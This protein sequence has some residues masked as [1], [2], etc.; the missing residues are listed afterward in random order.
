MFIISSIVFAAFLLFQRRYERVYGPRT[1]LGSLRNWQRTPKRS[2]G[3]LGWRKEYSLLKDEYILGHASIDNYLWLRFFKVLII[4]CF[5]GCLITWPVLFAVNAS[6]HAPG[7]GL[8]VLS[9]SHINPGPRYYASC[10][11]AWV[12]LGFVMF[13]ITRESRYYIRLRQQYYISPF[14]KSRISSRTVLFVQVPEELR[15]EEALRREFAGVKKVWLVNVPE[16]LAKDVEDRDKAA[17]KLENG[18]IKLLT[19]Y[20]KR[21][22]KLEK[23][24]QA[25]PSRDGGAPALD[26]KDRPSHRLPILK[27]IPLGKKVDTIDWSRSELH[28][29]IPQIAR[30]QHEHRNDNSLPQ[31]ACFIEF[32]SVRDAHNAELQC[33]SSKTNIKMSAEELGVVP[34]NVLWKNIIKPYS[35]VQLMKTLCT[36]FVWWLC[37]WWTIPVAVVGAISN[38]NV[39]S[40]QLILNT[41]DLANLCP[42][43][44]HKPCTFPQFH[45]QDSRSNLG[46]SHRFATCHVSP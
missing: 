12:F 17:A 39:S 5:V 11:V 37:I 41:H 34:E 33:D 23:K 19:N 8:D 28:R 42:P 26:K 10:L 24:G 40:P 7:T 46:S 31:G 2:A 15:N 43:V 13:V 35:K 30:T 32:A 1:Y 20:V 16:K 3:V 14:E 27:F 9:F 44:S 29:Q 18:E 22:M 36:A 6:G 4:I 38:I 21:Q 25:Q 45:Q